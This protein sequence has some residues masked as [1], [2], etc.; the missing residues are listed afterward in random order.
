MK[1]RVSITSTSSSRRYYLYLPFL[2][3]TAQNARGLNCLSQ[4]VITL[5]Y[6]LQTWVFN[7]I[8]GYYVTLSY[9]FVCGRERY[10]QT[11]SQSFIFIFTVGLLKTEKRNQYPRSCRTAVLAIESKS[12]RPGFTTFYLK[13]NKIETGPGYSKIL[14][15]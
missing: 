12:F 1:Q 8:V 4:R 15:F 5:N 6:R 11:G 7:I 10:N 13:A 14:W 2:I 3:T 9:Y